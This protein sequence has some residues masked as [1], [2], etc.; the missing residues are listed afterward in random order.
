VF[1]LNVDKNVFPQQLRLHRKLLNLKQEDFAKMLNVSD[2]T[3]SDWEL[4]KSIPDMDKILKICCKFKISFNELFGISSQDNNMILS[5]TEKKVI[6]AYRK[7]KQA[8]E[9]VHRVLEIEFGE[10][11]SKKEFIGE[12]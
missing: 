2:S 6:L 8:Q 5:P 11:L 3:V 4:G 10:E 1:N 7:K 9:Y 12:M